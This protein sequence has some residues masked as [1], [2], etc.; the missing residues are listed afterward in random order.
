MA[1]SDVAKSTIQ[2]GTTA[3]TQAGFSTLLILGEHNKFA[4]RFRLYAGPDDVL[5]DFAPGDPEYIAAARAFGQ[6]FRPSLVAIGRRVNTANAAQVDTV[7]IGT[8]ADADIRT[9]IFEGIEIARHV[10]VTAD[11]A[12]TVRTA[13]IAQINA[14]GVPVTAAEGGAGEMTVTAQWVGQPFALTLGGSS[15]TDYATS[16][17]TANTPSGETVTAALQAIVDAGAEFYGLCLV[18]RRAADITDAAEFVESRKRL[19]AFRVNGAVYTSA[20]DDLASDL[21]ALAYF[22]SLVF[23]SKR[24]WLFPEVALMAN[25]LSIDPD[26]GSSTWVHVRLVGAMPDQLT[27]TEEANLKTKGVFYYVTVGGVNVTLGGKVIGGEWVDVVLGIDWLNA[28]ISEAAAGIKI[29]AANGGAA[30][31]KIPYT[32]GGVA[33]LEESL[34]ARLDRATKTGFLADDPRF[35]VTAPRVQDLTSEQRASR[36]LPA[37]RWVANIAGAVHVSNFEGELIP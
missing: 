8:V 31:K 32:N 7:V 17:T 26:N 11:T 29:S 10:A 19:A 22:R 33:L 24:P 27:A 15:P 34:I 2:V 9:V 3:I 21:K 6:R 12:E 23:A 14:S 28:R 5:E 1:L 16:T 37:I 35:T 13:L 4:E 25:R 36:V 18:S 20:G 30:S